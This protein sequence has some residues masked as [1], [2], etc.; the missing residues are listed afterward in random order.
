MSVRRL[1]IVGAV[2]F[3]LAAPVASLVAYVRIDREAVATGS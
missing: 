3:G 1:T 2:L